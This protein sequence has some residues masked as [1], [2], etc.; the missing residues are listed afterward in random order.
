MSEFTLY[1]AVKELDRL[2]QEKE[3]PPFDLK[4]V[5][6]FALMLNDIRKDKNVYTDIDYIGSPFSKEI[7]DCI[8]DIGKKYG[9][10]EHWINNDVL[11]SGNS[12]EDMEFATGKLH[13]HPVD[14]SGL[15]V[16]RLSCLNTEDLL[17]MKVIAIDTAYMAV[18]L[19]GDFSRFKDFLDIEALMN[20]ENLNMSKLIMQT[21]D[22][23]VNNETYDLI[24]HY[25]K[26]HDVKLSNAEG[27]YDIVKER[28]RAILAARRREKEEIERE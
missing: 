9:F 14:D 13:F 18:S 17:R 2:L 16:I 23:V 11:L 8:A 3:T 21:S 1:D 22:Y 24:A 15:K 5:G 6:G 25:L 26:T 28:R 7:E 27:I 12:L 19:G 4:V 10:E 20:A